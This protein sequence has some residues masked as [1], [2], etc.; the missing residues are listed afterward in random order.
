VLADGQT[1]TQVAR[2]WGV[3]RQTI[4]GCEQ[5]SYRFVATSDYAHAIRLESLINDRDFHKQDGRSL[6]QA[7]CPTRSSAG[8]VVM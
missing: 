1:I 6:T 2:D 5:L 8:T 4:H 7:Q 3:S